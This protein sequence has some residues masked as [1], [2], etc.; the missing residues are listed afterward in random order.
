M[1]AAE[2]VIHR[3]NKEYISKIVRPIFQDAL[4]QRAKQKNKSLGDWL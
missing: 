4:V 3:E 2:E 1:I